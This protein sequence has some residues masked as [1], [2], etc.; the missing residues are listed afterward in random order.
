[1]QL[2]L[3]NLKGK[4]SIIKIFNKLERKN[5][6]KFEGENFFKFLNEKFNK[7]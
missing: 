1:M 6:N 2:H 5:F 4:I 3:K 7:I